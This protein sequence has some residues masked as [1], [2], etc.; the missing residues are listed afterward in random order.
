MF[1]PIVTTNSISSLYTKVDKVIADTDVKQ[2]KKDVTITLLNDLMREDR[3]SVCE[4]QELCDL[5]NIKLSK[6]RENFYRA[7]HCKRYGDMT[8]ETKEY[9]MACILDDM[10]I[11][12]NPNYATQ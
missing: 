10:R 4:V 8:H 5:H 11:V 9:L 1:E 7:L 6:D 2:V 3:F 12:L